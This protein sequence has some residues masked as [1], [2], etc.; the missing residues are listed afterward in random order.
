MKNKIVAMI[1][2][3][4]SSIVSF[5]QSPDSEI[6]NESV[7][8]ELLQ[9]MIYTRINQT[10]MSAGLDSLLRHEVLDAAAISQAEDNMDL[11]RIDTK[12]DFGKRMEKA[13]G[14]NKAV[15]M[16]AYTGTSKGKNAYTYL[17]VTSEFIEKF[18]KSKK[19]KKTLLTPDYFYGGIGVVSDPEKKRVYVSL[20][21]GGINALNLGVDLRNDLAVKYSKSSRG[22]EQSDGKGC[23][24]C[25]K[26]KNWEKLYNGMYVKDNY[27]YLEYDNLKELKTLLKR[28]K[29]GFAIDIIQ[30]DQYQCDKANIM[31]NN[32]ISKGILL[33][34][35]FSK[36]LLKK[37]EREDDSNS[38]LGPISKIKG[39]YEKAFENG[40]EL[41]LL[42]VQSKM[43]CKTIEQTFTDEGDQA[44]LTKLNVYPDT[45]IA[46]DADA[47][48]P[49]VDKQFLEFRIPFEVNKFN[50]EYK[51]IKPFIDA[52]N[53]PEFVVTDIFIEA[54]S[55]LEGDSSIN[56]RLQKNRAESIVKA[57]QGS[58]LSKKTDLLK[59]ENITT[60]DS[61][62]IWQEQVKGKP[63]YAEWA[64]MTKLEVKAALRK[65]E[66]LA[67]FDSLLDAQRFA[68]VKM[69]V[70]YDITGSKE[71]PF[72]IS[73]L[74]KAIEK[75]DAN[76]ALRIQ[77]YGV[78][79]VL[80]GKY[81]ANEFVNMDIPKT[82]QFVTLEV[83]RIFMDTKFLKKGEM[84]ESLIAKFDSLY[85]M[86][87]ENSFAAFNKYLMTIKFSEIENAKQVA[88]LQKG[89]N[90]L[91]G[92]KI[93][94]KY[95]DALNLEYQFKIIARFDTV[96]AGQE[97]VN[98]AIE[99]IRKIYNIE[100][101]TWQNSL[102]LGYIFIKHKDYDFACKIMG[103][104]LDDKD[105]GVNLVYAYISSACHNR[106]NIFTPDFRKAMSRAKEM[107]ESRYC[108]L[109]G[110]P[111]LTFQ[112]LDHP[113]I[114]EE[115]CAT[116]N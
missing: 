66:N 50:Y 18:N 48:K 95:V 115:F 51:D 99:K 64:K 11:Q 39:K 5:A 88:E 57:I 97:I 71:L 26:F 104:F 60:T 28:S 69:E 109:F 53:E 67:L 15:Y 83:N 54:H 96:E 70:T 33:K 3:S 29:D 35:W 6:D 32:L 10:R 21:L 107:D 81:A 90:A 87:P 58:K 100:T 85:K 45:S 25:D 40:Y 1:F 98:A 16:A 65:S 13:G 110:N 27:V 80:T 78:K 84:D 62:E 102:K 20:S 92:G 14:T 61:W 76:L 2:F 44:S 73:Q 19:D 17:E 77:K 31:D 41:N 12:D 91:Y 74:K 37:N 46:G 114:K 116:C 36:K 63:Q 94:P 72:V 56:S 112:V 59:Q 52:L 24:A 9:S 105:V 42:V 8:V 55:S 86:A 38:F 82:A 111:N 75:K 30:R 79:Q 103:P 43:I 23:K 4:L 7:D 47:W 113:L 34:P 49:D 93:T 22:L 108:D 89:I 106:A 68:L 101:S